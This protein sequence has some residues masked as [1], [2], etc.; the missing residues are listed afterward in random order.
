M[1]DPPFDAVEVNPL[2]PP[3]IVPFVYQ[4]VDEIPPANVSEK[5]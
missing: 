4:F 3:E 5:K 2:D 1:T